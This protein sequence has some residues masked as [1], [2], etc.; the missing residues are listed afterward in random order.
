MARISRLPRHQTAPELQALFEQIESNGS[1]VLHL[2][3]TLAHCPYLCRDVIRFGNKLLNK[4][5][6]SDTLR[7]LA[8]LVVSHLTSAKYEQIK[9]EEI[10]RQVGV[11]EDKIA[12]VA[13]WNTS[14]LFDEKERAVLR[15]AKDTTQQVK[16]SDEAFDQMRLYFSESEIVE[17]TVIVG[18]YNMISRILETL[19][20][21]LEQNP[22]AL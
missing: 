14:T 20:V 21:E 15:F 4:G 9:H 8:I 22:T 7:E 17:F 3:Q 2:Y 12:A 10:A 5:G 16:A 6:V 18:F 1:Q 13:D 11:P 19:G